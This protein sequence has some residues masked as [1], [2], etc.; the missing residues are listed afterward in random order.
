MEININVNFNEAKKPAFINDSV[1]DALESLKPI[2]SKI[3]DDFSERATTK[4]SERSTAIRPA[5]ETEQ[6]PNPENAP[7]PNFAIRKVGIIQCVDEEMTKNYA[8]AFENLIEA[9]H[10]GYQLTK[11]PGGSY[12]LVAPDGTKVTA[13]SDEPVTHS[14]L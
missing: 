9:L 7:M 3:V 8:D 14:G 10:Q 13:N 5:E 11:G 1:V 2:I 4:S 12:T 6:N